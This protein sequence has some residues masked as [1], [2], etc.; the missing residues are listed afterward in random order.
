MISVEGEVS[1]GGFLLRRRILQQDPL[2]LTPTCPLSDVS[3]QTSGRMAPRQQ[4]LLPGSGIWD[5]RWIAL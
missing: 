4:D 3:P 2:S 5:M 1:H